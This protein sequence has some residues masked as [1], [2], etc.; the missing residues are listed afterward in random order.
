VPAEGAGEPCWTRAE[1]D[2]LS[3]LLAA[4]IRLGVAYISR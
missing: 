3:S 2:F 1:Q 4:P